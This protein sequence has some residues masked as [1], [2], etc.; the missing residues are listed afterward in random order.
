[1]VDRTHWQPEKKQIENAPPRILVVSLCKC[2]AYKPMLEAIRSSGIKEIVA[3][4]VKVPP[5]KT[6]D[7][8]RRPSLPAR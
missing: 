5:T 4:V 1:M 6:P 7:H 3:E 8:Q 2:E